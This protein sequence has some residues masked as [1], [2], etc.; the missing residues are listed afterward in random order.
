MD[1]V[2]CSIKLSVQVPSLARGQ[3][4]LKRLDEL[5]YMS[6]TGHEAEFA[7]T[8]DAGQRRGAG[9]S[10]KPVRHSEAAQQAALRYF[11][12]ASSIHA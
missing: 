6:S 5:C 1:A 7:G 9:L 12:K 3:V 8:L 2:F 4:M 11:R 10:S